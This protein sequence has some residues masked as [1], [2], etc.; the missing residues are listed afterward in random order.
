MIAAT[1]HAPKNIAISTIIYSFRIQ[2]PINAKITVNIEPNIIVTIIDNMLS[3][4]SADA[5]LTSTTPANASFAIS[6]KNLPICSL[7][8]LFLS[9]NSFL[10]IPLCLDNV[11][12][13]IDI[14]QVYIEVLV[15]GVIGVDG[16][17][18][19]LHVV[20]HDLFQHDPLLVHD[21]ECIP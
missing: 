11:Q 16:D 12:Y 8:S 20:R 15:V 2:Y 19:P 5:I 14:T 9:L 17:D 10:S 7:I 3:A 13:L 1:A 4:G 21:H 6:R 18:P